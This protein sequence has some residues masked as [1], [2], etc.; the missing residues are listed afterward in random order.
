MDE[1]VLAMH[2]WRD[3]GEMIADVARLGYLDGAVLDVT[4][5]RGTFWKVFKPRALTGLVYPDRMVFYRAGERMWTRRQQVDMRSLDYPDETWDSV[6]L[7]A[8]YKLNG[9]PDPDVDER[10]GVHE[11]VARQ[12]KL[13]L[14]MAGVKECA[15]VVRLRGFLLVKCMDQVESGRQWWQT[16]MV[17]AA[18]LE[19]GQYRKVDRFD[20]LGKARKQPMAEKRTVL[21]DGTVK[22]RKARK[23]RHAHG[24]GS[25][26]LVFQRM[27]T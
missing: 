18:A 5:G 23:Q 25:T 4:Y 8:P 19:G 3:N 10:Y 2:R 22:L 24:R 9:K 1:P 12:E 11:P 20:L 15:R 13:E 21:K 14:M 27:R 26:L 6:V 7:D 16:D 17:T